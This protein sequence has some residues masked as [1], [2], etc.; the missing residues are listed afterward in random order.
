MAFCKFCG[1]ELVN[2]KCTCEE[3]KAANSQ[4]PQ[5]G[6][7]QASAADTAPVSSEQ[8]APERAAG[9]NSA[10]QPS[11]AAFR[12]ADVLTCLLGGIVSPIDSIVRQLPNNDPWTGIIL[13]ITQAVLIFLLS[14]IHI[15]FIS[16]GSTL[17]DRALIGVFALLIVLI[18]IVV[19]AA[20]TFL[21]KLLTKEKP[22]FLN[23]LSA[24]GRATVMGS[25]FIV[26]SFVFGYFAP[27]IAVLMLLLAIMSWMIQSVFVV[28]LEEE[29][30]GKSLKFWTSFLSA[31]AVLIVLYLLAL[32]FA[33]YTASQYPLGGLGSMW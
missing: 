27:D 16:D 7:T 5:P 23:V 12:I 30:T 6:P 32:L 1:K 25:L 26:L 14:L 3:W 29:R 4:A 20:V 2:G 11:K 8:A 21:V 31:V 22:N 28:D 24:F 33:K 19:T 15:P 10:P 13:G 9:V 17:K 18:G